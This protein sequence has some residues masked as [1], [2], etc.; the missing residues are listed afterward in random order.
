MNSLTTH[1]NC[2][3]ARINPLTTDVNLAVAR[4][5]PLAT[6]VKAPHTGYNA[7]LVELKCVD[8][9][10][11]RALDPGKRAPTLGKTT[12]PRIIAFLSATFAARP[13]A[14]ALR[15]VVSRRRSWKHRTAQ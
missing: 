10:R 3:A 13:A 6:D 7:A 5:N 15:Q 9:L 14:S 12:R 11:D 2:A 8:T 4:I 1:V